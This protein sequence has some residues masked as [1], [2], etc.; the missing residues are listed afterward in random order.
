M[1]NK[2]FEDAYMKVDRALVI[3]EEIKTM[4]DVCPP[5]SYVLETDTH[6]H[7]RATLA[8]KN[9]F[10]LKKVTIRCGELFHNLRSAID[11]AY[12]EAISPHVDEKTHKAVQFP[13]S[14]NTSTYEQTI[15]SRQGDKAGESFFNALKELK[16]FHGEGGN[17]Y[18]VLLHEINIV[19]KHKYPT[20]AGNFTKITSTEIQT[21]IPDFP[22]GIVNCGIGQFRKDVVWKSN[23]YDLNNVGSIVPPFLHLY[24]KE[25][26][27]S[28]ETWFYLNNPKYSGE[29]IG[30]MDTLINETRKALEIME[31]GLE[32]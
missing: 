18:I 12:W 30:T 31:N 20:P 3:L 2:V 17:V 4:M 16:A 14:K 11:H 29:V 8:K 32:K 15:K 13:L 23:N 21:Q 1:N 24:H 10:S 9:Y 19:D 25:L 6:T 26:D 7:E 22:R 5:F 28:V 27:T